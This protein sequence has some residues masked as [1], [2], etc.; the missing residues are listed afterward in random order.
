MSVNQPSVDPLL[1]QNGIQ[2][3]YNQLNKLFD[4]KH[5]NLIENKLAKRQAC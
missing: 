2:R 5:V 3:L 4:I 1:D